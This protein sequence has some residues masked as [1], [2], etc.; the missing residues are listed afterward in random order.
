MTDT[1]GGNAAQIAYWNDRAAAN[2]TALQ[3]KIDAL[4]APITA[5]ALDAAAPAP[6]ETVL[7]VGCGCGATVLA[8]AERVGPSGRVL[9]VDVSVPMAARASQRIAD[10]GLAHAEVLVTDASTHSFS[11][12][13]DLLF[14]RFGVMFF[15]DPTAAFANLR[16]GM[17]PGGRLLCAVWRTLPE[18]SWFTVPL[19]AALPLLPPQPQADP[20]APGPFAFADFERVRGLLSAAGWRDISAQPRDVPMLVGGPGQ[21]D[22]AT[23]F[24]MRLGALA[25][26]LSETDPAVH[27]A[28]RQAVQTAL[29]GHEGPGGVMLGGSIWL[30]SARA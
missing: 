15:A 29:A 4:F 5:L 10:A 3:E 14:S 25:R 11:G 20:F 17:R 16:R 21:L 24:A 6:G 2:W 7:D 13:A 26:I 12:E 23:D 9:G 8:L 18:N 1:D 19:K 27:P 22:K 28:V 30:V